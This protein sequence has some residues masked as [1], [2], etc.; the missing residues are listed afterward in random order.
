MLC[1][2][3]GLHPWGKGSGRRVWGRQPRPPWVLS[4]PC[5][6]RQVLTTPWGPQASERQLLLQF[7]YRVDAESSRSGQQTLVQTLC[8][9]HRRPAGR[10]GAG[11]VFKALK[12]WVWR[13][14]ASTLMLG[15]LSAQGPG[16]AAASS[17]FLLPDGGKAAGWAG[18]Q[19]PVV[20]V[21]AGSPSLGGLLPCTA[22]TAPGTGD[23]QCG[24]GAA[25]P[26]FSPVEGL[27]QPLTLRTCHLLRVAPTLYQVSQVHLSVRLVIN[28]GK[29]KT[30]YCRQSN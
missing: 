6:M 5:S 11:N 14:P 26:R 8:A 24:G 18:T 13:R 10:Q 28:L 27:S 17:D 23:V 4:N 19:E 16:R 25:V 9:K 29:I 22:V 20:G 21:P 1:R 15:G 12:E 7:Q 30:S 3:L 2:P